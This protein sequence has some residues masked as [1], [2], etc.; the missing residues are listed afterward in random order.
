[1]QPIKGPELETKLNECN[2]LK[3]RSG[4]IIESQGDKNIQIEY[5][6]PVQ[7]APQLE[8]MVEQ[9][10][11]EQTITSSPPFPEKLIMPCSIEY[12]D[13]DLLGESK[14]LCVKIPLLQAI[15]DIP[16]YAKSI[17]ELCTKN[18]KRKIKLTP[19]IHVIGTLPDLLSG[20][21]TPVKYVDPGNPII[22]VKINGCSPN[23]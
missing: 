11:H 10:T 4:W 9:K 13:F 2:E 1:M 14:N 19:T 21:E 23:A 3:L 7:Q 20:R 22:M 5:L 18:T 6:L 8:N 16:I 17:K 12:L 15:Q